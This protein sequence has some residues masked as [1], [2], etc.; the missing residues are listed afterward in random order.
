MKASVAVLAIM[1]LTPLWVA[2][3]ADIGVSLAVTLNG[4][5]AI[6]FTPQA[7]ALSPLETA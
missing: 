6:S 3:L 1:G 5:R 4:M 2:I 7:S